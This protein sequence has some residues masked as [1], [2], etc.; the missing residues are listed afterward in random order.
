MF[1]TELCFLKKRFRQALRCLSG[2][3]WL[4]DEVINFYLNMLNVR[5]QEELTSQVFRFA[6]QSNIGNSPGLVAV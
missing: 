4:N 3:N 5:I 2:T 6:L 1:S